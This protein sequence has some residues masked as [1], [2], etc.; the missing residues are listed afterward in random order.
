MAASGN[1]G[2]MRPVNI[3][4]FTQREDKNPKLPHVVQ[5]RAHNTFASAS[6]APVFWDTI[7]HDQVQGMSEARAFAGWSG[8]GLREV[9][10]S[11][12]GPHTVIFRRN[13]LPSRQCVDYAPRCLILPNLP[14]KVLDVIFAEGLAEHAAAAFWYVWELDRA[15]DRSG[16][17]W[18]QRRAQSVGGWDWGEDEFDDVMSAARRLALMFP[19]EPNL[20]PLKSLPIF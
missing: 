3:K 7:R 2:A 10:V 5:Q 6:G 1:S 18:S 19:D 17:R 13:W 4:F 12:P 14:Q 20:A 9:T 16:E 8:K 15:L 11:G